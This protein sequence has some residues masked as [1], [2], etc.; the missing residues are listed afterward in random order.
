M[1]HRYYQQQQQP[2]IDIN[3]LDED[4]EIRFEYDRNGNLRS[5]KKIRR[6]N[7]C[8]SIFLLAAAL[9]FLRLA[10]WLFA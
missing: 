4:H 2:L 10:W 9:A 8:S 1:E 6:S 3:N 7:G 5:V